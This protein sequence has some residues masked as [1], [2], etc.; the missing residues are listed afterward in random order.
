MASLVHA[1]GHVMGGRYG[2]PHGV[3][4][5][6]LLP[7]AL[8]LLWPSLGDGPPEAA[9]LADA[10]AAL[11]A[12]LPLPRRLREAGVGA[13]DLAAIAAATL[14]DSMIAHAPRPVSEAEV[15]GLLEAAW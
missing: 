6:I 7:P 12:G 11:H 4:H 9:G 10:V 3:A 14:G 2:L 15:R 13:A 8:R 1:I 5:G